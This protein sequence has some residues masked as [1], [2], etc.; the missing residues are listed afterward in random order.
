MSPA[1]KPA[2][3]TANKSRTTS[4]EEASPGG[5]GKAAAPA[6]PPVPSGGADAAA[7][8][9]AGAPAKPAAGQTR[10]PK[11]QQAVVVVHGM[12]EPKPL[13]TL[14]SFVEAVWGR[15]L[16]PHTDPSAAGRSDD[17]LWLVPDMRT[18]LKELG[19]VT[20]RRN[21]DGI[22]T[23]FY[24]LYWS[25][26]LVDN[27][28]AQVNAWLR[29]LLLR[30][31]HQVPRE[32]VKVW[33]VLWV[34][35]LA[36]AALA[37]SI[38][39]GGSL[40][41][42][43]T[44]ISEAK[45]IQNEWTLAASVLTGFV[46]FLALRWRL[47][48]VD[49]EWKDADKT[50]PG[51]WA[52]ETPRNASLHAGFSRAALWGVPVATILVLFYLFPWSVLETWKSWALLAAGLIAFGL[53]T[54]VG[55]YF[56]D[57]ARYV[58][59]S[60]DAVEAR[61]RIRE[62]GVELLRALHGPLEGEPGGRYDYGNKIPY[63]RIVVVGH[64]LGSIVAYD[65]L[66]LFWLERGPTG[67]NPPD[68]EALNRLR[69]MDDFLCAEEGRL[70]EEKDKPD[71]EREPFAIDRFREL[72]GKV[73]KSLAQQPGGWRV[74]DF[75]TLGSPLTHAEFLVSRDRVA[76]EERKAERMFPTCPPMLEHGHKRS[77]LYPNDERDYRREYAHHAAMF[78]AVRWTNIHDPS[79]FPAFGDF[80]SGPCAPNFGPGVRDVAVNMRHRGLL[81]RVFT[82]THY[83]NPR[84]DGRASDDEGKKLGVPDISRD[85][86][87]HITL[88]RKA[89][90]LR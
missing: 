2:R 36:A 33:I 84:A 71:A 16:V 46:V 64:S 10:A 51:I 48:I 12:G 24:E 89:L 50:F 35:V 60:P 57:V 72:Q 38:G 8:L 45:V 39:I 55:P 34:L 27:K 4:Q 6:E 77:F 90:A 9:G 18:G 78:S 14:R 29:G 53:T 62:R 23:D 56:G 37:L 20:T 32:T 43:W 41:K 26:L 88:L 52:G 58:R 28:L 82:H 85:D 68:G 70:A 61:S 42:L 67:R 47:A 15:G 80:I 59:T 25:D 76:F 11:R 44:L 3:A 83:W 40:P 30:W 79:R 86:R 87:A 22:T 5:E 66:R 19:R 17:D 73:A 81:P 75:V 69:E 54:I 1:K 13:D 65:I 63:E 31:P 49:E 7:S 74:S 21:N